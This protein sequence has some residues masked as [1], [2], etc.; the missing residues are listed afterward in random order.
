MNKKEI[1][2]IGLGRMGANM[3]NRML[4]SG[5]INLHVFNRTEDKAKLLVEKGATYKSTIKELIEGLW[6]EKKIVWIMLPSG[7]ITESVFQE[8][9]NILKKGDII[10]DGGNSNFH[11]T[12]R[13]HKECEARGI[14][15]LDVGVSGGIIAA[16]KGYPMMIGGKEETYNYCKEIF[17]SFGI[18]EGFGL[19]GA[20]GS[21]HYVKMIH[22]AI[23]YGMMQ[24]ISE[25]FDLLENGRIKNLDLLKI[26]HIWNH[27]TIVSSFLMEMVE[28]ALTKDAKLNYLKPYIEDNGEGR[29]SAI[30]A[31]EFK[32]PFVVNSYALNARYISRDLNS[33]SFRLTAAM[34][35]EFGGHAIKKGE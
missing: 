12:L 10:I 5:K 6:Q 21:G 15:M 9:K 8:V 25:G 28:N 17:E 16:D 2:L 22:N 1:A 24:A 13:R 19:V 4:D 34:R 14:E 27:G 18:N 35:A 11:D 33:F 23:E 29:W 32:V 3:A 31:L 26:S 30:E 7:E 20:G